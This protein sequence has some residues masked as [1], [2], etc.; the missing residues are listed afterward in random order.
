M[1]YKFGALQADNK[2]TGN[3]LAL[4]KIPA[5]NPACQLIITMKKKEDDE[6]S[7][8]DIDK[9]VHNELKIIMAEMKKNVKNK[10]PC[11]QFSHSHQIWNEY[12]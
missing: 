12:C 2:G 5:L 1:N 7:S 10:K 9:E 11:Y 8:A 6:D 4:T 3:C